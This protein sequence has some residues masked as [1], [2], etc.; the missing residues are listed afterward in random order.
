MRS[1]PS[2]S[3]SAPAPPRHAAPRARA[4]TSGRSRRTAGSRSFAIMAATSSTRRTVCMAR[5]RSP[6]T[7]RKIGLGSEAANTSPVARPRSDGTS[8]KACPRGKSGSGW[9]RSPRP[10][11]KPVSA[12]VRKNGT[13]APSARAIACSSFGSR[14][15]RSARSTAAAS[16]DPPPR[17]AAT[18]MRLR[19]CT[20]R[21]SPSAA[22]AAVT[23]VSSGN[24]STTVSGAS[25]SSSSS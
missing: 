10:V 24:P 22:S 18:G 19:S 20:R 13:S 14:S 23:S 1:A 5:T 6:S 15:P 11:P 2:R 12:P 3:R 17:P 7:A 9:M 8:T 16:D 21:V 4:A 25:A